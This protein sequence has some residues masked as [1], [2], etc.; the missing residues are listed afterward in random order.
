MS[1]MGEVD[2]GQLSWCLLREVHNGSGKSSGGESS[3]EKSVG[4]I[5]LLGAGNLLS[6]DWLVRQFRAK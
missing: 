3:R 2:R 4:A 1:S 6:S 5:L